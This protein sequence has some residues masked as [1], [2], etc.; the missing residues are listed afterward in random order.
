MNPAPIPI[1]IPVPVPVGQPEPEP[2]SAPII[3]P[4]TSAEPH[5]PTVNSNKST[6]RSGTTTTRIPAEIPPPTPAESSKTNTGPRGDT[7]KLELKVIPVVSHTVEDEPPT[8]MDEVLVDPSSPPLA[9]E[10]VQAQV[11]LEPRRDDDI[12][13]SD[14]PTR[15]ETNSTQN[16]LESSPSTPKQLP[17]QASS[18]M[19]KKPR[20][21][22]RKRMSDAEKAQLLAVA[23]RYKDR[24]GMPPLKERTKLVDEMGF[25]PQTIYNWFR[26]QRMMQKAPQVKSKSPPPKSA[27]MYTSTYS[28]GD[29]YPLWHPRNTLRL[30]LTLKQGEAGPDASD[31][32]ETTVEGELKSGRKRAKGRAFSLGD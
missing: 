13:S 11:V 26:K 17:H 20:K 6:I 32:P 18:L 25:A 8:R 12:P 29:S 23:D 31:G 30:A 16:P 9:E 10:E 28:Y 27:H 15:Q 14:T 24:G 22:P 3:K 21:Q 4:Q 19:V 5:N 7:S 2:A 1:P